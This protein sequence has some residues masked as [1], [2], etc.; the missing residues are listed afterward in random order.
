[1]RLAAIVRQQIIDG[2][3]RPGGPAPS[4]TFLSREHGHARPTCSRALRILEDEGLLT[5][6]PGL[7]GR[8]A[9][10]TGHR[11]PAAKRSGTFRAHHVA[12]CP[13]LMR[14][15]EISAAGQTVCVARS[16]WSERRLHRTRPT[17][18]LTPLHV[19]DL[20]RDGHQVSW[21]RS[22]SVRATTKIASMAPRPRSSASLPSPSPVRW[23]LSAPGPTLEHR[24]CHQPDE[25]VPSPCARPPLR[26]LRA[27]SGPGQARGLPAV[28]APRGRGGLRGQGSPPARQPT[29]GRLSS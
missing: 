19:A 3:L 2:K 22:C 23:L 6:I 5:R 8:N 18:R 15:A 9:G 10:R 16:S 24:R 4:I 17:G 20:G 11:Q 12:I 21:F 25:P 1:M 7:A 14:T 29:T 28:P 13:E 27:V 26:G